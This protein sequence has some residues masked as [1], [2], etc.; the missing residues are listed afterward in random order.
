MSSS[1]EYA[2]GR[3]S[4]LEVTLLSPRHWGQIIG[5]AGVEEL[6]KVLGE[7]W[8][9]RLIHGD[10]L[11]EALPGALSAAEDELLE[12]GPDQRLARAILL[13]RDVR[14][15]RYT[16]KNMASGGDG[17]VPLERDGTLPAQ[18]FARAWNDPASADELPK[19][20]RAAMGGIQEVSQGGSLRVDLLMDQLAADIERVH[21]GSL[22]SGLGSFVA[23]RLELRNFLTAGR[24][25][26]EGI[27]GGQLGGWLFPGGLHSIEEVMEACRKGRLPDLLAETAGFETAAAALKEGLEGGSFL[28]FQRESDRILLETVSSL[29]KRSAG[30]GLL[31]SYVLGREMETVHLNLV[32][33]AKRAEMNT[34]KLQMRLPR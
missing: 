10:S 34:A 6:L 31:A 16:W 18:L 23:A 27:A 30:P 17:A 22:D 13:R 26:I 11:E 24:L 4:A 20:F 19:E 1:W 21:L 29:G 2:A 32:A 8:Y 5:S 9:G 25:G 3:I 14:N 15:A 12:L 33:A 7:T 28:A